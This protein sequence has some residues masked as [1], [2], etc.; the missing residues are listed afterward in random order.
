M[1]LEPEV[2]HLVNLG[3]LR[4]TS[5]ISKAHTSGCVDDDI[6]RDN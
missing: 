3:G 4:N 6:F 5:G 1:G 2:V